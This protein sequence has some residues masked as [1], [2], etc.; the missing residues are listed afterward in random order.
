MCP[1]VLFYV[2]VS[3]TNLMSMPSWCKFTTAIWCVMR[4]RASPCWLG[5]QLCTVGSYHP[6]PLR[7]AHSSRRNLHA[8]RTPRQSLPS[9]P[10]NRNGVSAAAGAPGTDAAADALA[11]V[12]VNCSS[13]S[14]SELSA[15]WLARCST[16]RR[17]WLKQRACCLLTCQV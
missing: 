1:S 9:V 3:V 11:A 8:R 4:K 6:R 14:S 2:T 13:S 7:D 5:L 16:N 12:G 15:C 17:L 10:T